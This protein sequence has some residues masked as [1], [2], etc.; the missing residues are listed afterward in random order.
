MKTLMIKIQCKKKHMKVELSRPKL[1][2]IQNEENRI[3]TG[4]MGGREGGLLEEQQIIGQKGGAVNEIEM[5]KKKKKKGK[6]K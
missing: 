6:G 4:M 5:K 1:K 3:A 2:Q